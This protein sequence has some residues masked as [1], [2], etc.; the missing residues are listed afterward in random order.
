LQI[1]CTHFAGEGATST[2]YWNKFLIISEKPRFGAFHIK[3]TRCQPPP[4]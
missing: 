2:G 3:S 1:V 4:S